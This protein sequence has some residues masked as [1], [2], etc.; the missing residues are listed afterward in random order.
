VVVDSEA[1]VVRCIFRR[2]AALG[3]VR[4]LQEELAAMGITSKRWTSAAGRSWGGRPLARGA[5]YLMLQNRIY[6]GDIV[7]RGKSYPEEHKPIIE[8][9][10]WD[11]VQVKLAANDSER[12]TGTRVRHPSLLAGL[13]FDG[14]GHR[15]TPTHA[16]KKG[17]RLPLLCLA[18]ADQPRPGRC[19]RRIAHPRRRY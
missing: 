6:R 15:M 9:P 17:A 1:D 2:Y 13:L 14:N 19:S 5:L 3:S 10:L 7:P 18:S 4:L 11:I 8:P 16:V 12:S